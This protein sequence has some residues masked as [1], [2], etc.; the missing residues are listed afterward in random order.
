MGGVYVAPG[1][2]TFGNGLVD[3]CLGTAV[4]F[5][6]RRATRRG[7]YTITFCFF[8]SFTRCNEPHLLVPPAHVGGTS[9][10]YR[11]LN[12]FDLYTSA[13]GTVA[14]HPMHPCTQPRNLFQRC[15]FWNF[16][17]PATLGSVS[18]AATRSHAAPLF[19]THR[20]GNVGHFD[21]QKVVVGS[22]SLRSRH[23]SGLRAR[24]VRPRGVPGHPI[25][26]LEVSHN[27]IR[28]PIMIPAKRIVV[29]G[30]FDHS[31]IRSESHIGRN[32][33]KTHPFRLH[34]GPGHPRLA[35]TCTEIHACTH[36]DPCQR[37]SDGKPVWRFS[38]PTRL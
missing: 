6:S 4:W 18:A 17:S 33:P 23:G 7:L 28:V 11:R 13:V 26:K 8:G 21:A 2:T 32:P 5:L 16:P 37:D 15:A 24:H 31:A 22:V 38:H 25:S 30:S 34:S 29:W 9:T 19:V 12:K 27:V 14:R 20:R 3:T 1:I 10:P 35:R 36:D